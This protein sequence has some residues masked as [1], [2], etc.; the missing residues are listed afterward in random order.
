MFSVS[1]KN[2]VTFSSEVSG[3]AEEG[4]AELEVIKC[5]INREG[6][7]KRVKGDFKGMG[8]NLKPELADS[9]DYLRVSSVDVVQAIVR[10]REVKKRTEGDEDAVFFWNG[11]NYLLKMIT[12]LNF[13][14]GNR[15][16][17][18]WS[19]FDFARNP[20]CIPA[21]MEG[22]ND[23][24]QGVAVDPQHLDGGYM[25]GFTFAGAVPRV[26]AEVAGE[27]R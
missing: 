26:V 24:M 21:P 13:M 23:F 6:Y 27:R 15:T 5:I 22:G 25:D 14:D 18:K 7:L 11:E 19:G 1:T 9:L 3:T 17:R 16:L 20:F 4:G 8:R 10:W 12:D 2:P